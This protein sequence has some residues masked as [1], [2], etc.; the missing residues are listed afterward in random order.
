MIAKRI[1]ASSGGGGGGGGGHA[2]SLTNYISKKDIAKEAEEVLYVDGRNFLCD[3]FESQQ[4][5]MVALAQ[6]CVRSKNPMRH[7]ILSWQEGE[8]PDRD[9]VEEAVTITLEELGLEVHQT[10]FA[11]HNDTDNTHLHLVVNRVHP[12]TLK[13]VKPN[14][15]FDIEALHRAVARIEHSQGWKPE[16]R[17]RYQVLEDGR[18]VRRSQ[19]KDRSRGPS[20]RARDYEARTGEKSAQRIAKEKAGPIIEEAQSWGE[21]H[22][23]LAELGMRYEKKGSGA[24]IW[25]GELAVKA[26][27]GGRHCSFRRLQSRLGEFEVSQEQKSS[28]QKERE[29]EPIKPGMLGWKDYAAERSEYYKGRSQEREAAQRRQDEA[30]KALLARQKKERKEILGGKW[31]GRGVALNALRSILAAQQAAEKAELKEKRDQQ[32]KALRERYSKFPDFETWLRREYSPELAK[33]WRY[34]DNP[35]YELNRLSGDR[36]VE[37]EPQDI[38][39]Y[40]AEV[41]GRQVLYRKKSSSGRAQVSFVDTGRE[42]EV[43][44]ADARGAVLAALQLAAQKWGPNVT[45]NGTSEY[46]RLCAEVAVEHGIRLANLEPQMKREKEKQRE[47]KEREKQ[48]E[49][50]EKERRR[51]EKEREKEA[52]RAQRK[53]DRE[54]ER[55]RG[56]GRGR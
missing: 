13:V 39:S 43:H 36:Y 28:Q 25:V 7:Y 22:Q 31:K 17:A 38:R 52:K 11:L 45:V 40:E 33:S 46:K 15:G 8:H 50:E 18:V 51:R 2:R 4:A 27:S 14:R 6:D 32:R 29:P 56:G 24:V 26:S 5:E 19:K 10:M 23:G 21:L 41:R 35:E 20:E 48:A 1:S 30:W 44:E 12:D 53:K 9:Q 34:R 55:S 3:D 49:R 37:P 42:I 54:K 16:K 47:E